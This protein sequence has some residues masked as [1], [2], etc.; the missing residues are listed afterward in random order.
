MFYYV[1]PVLAFFLQDYEAD[2]N[3]PS[4]LKYTKRHMY[5]FGGVLGAISFGVLFPKLLLAW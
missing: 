1:D 5:I 2:D 3:V 4:G